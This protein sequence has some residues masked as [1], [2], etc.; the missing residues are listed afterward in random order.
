MPIIAPYSPKSMPTFG[1]YFETQ[2]NVSVL[3]VNGIRYKS[4]LGREECSYDD[5]AKGGVNEVIYRFHQARK[6]Q[7]T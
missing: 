6:G 7:T 4:I 1:R 5:R 2:T 3:T